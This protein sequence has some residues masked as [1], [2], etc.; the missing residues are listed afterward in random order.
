MNENKTI[1][2]QT[3]GYLK[4]SFRLFYFKNKRLNKIAPLG[5]AGLFVCIFMF[6]NCKEVQLTSHNQVGSS[7]S[8]ASPT[9][10]P[11]PSDPNVSTPSSFGSLI[12]YLSTDTSK[13][14]Q[15]TFTVGQSAGVD[16]EGFK[17]GSNNFKWTIQRGFTTIVDAAETSVT[18]LHHSII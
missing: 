14:P 18:H 16:F 7:G 9:P 1:L 8:S 15:D 6:Q 3:I 13:T 5:L 11:S 12:A 17:N 10:Y 2:S 4:G